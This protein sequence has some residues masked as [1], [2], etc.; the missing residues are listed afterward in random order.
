MVRPACIR[1]QPESDLGGASGLRR[2]AQASF[3][4]RGPGYDPR[5]RLRSR[6]VALRGGVDAIVVA[7]AWQSGTVRIDVLARGACA[8][9]EVCL[10]LRFDRGA[11]P[12]KQV[13]TLCSAL[14]APILRMTRCE[15]D[16]EQAFLR[17][18]SE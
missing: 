12:E 13:F 17:A 16:L 1:V 8:E 6:V 2:V 10:T 14:S 9:D 11:L 3:E 7:F 15:D 18:I 4:P 5:L